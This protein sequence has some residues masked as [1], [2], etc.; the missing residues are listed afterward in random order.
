MYV[1]IALSSDFETGSTAKEDLERFESKIKNNDEDIFMISCNNRKKPKI[2]EEGIGKTKKVDKDYE[3][4][5]YYFV[6]QYIDDGVIEKT[7]GK[8]NKM[9][10]ETYTV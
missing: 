9:L 1:R 6:I 5:C 8:E 3:E 10:H 4:Q 2:I 7:I